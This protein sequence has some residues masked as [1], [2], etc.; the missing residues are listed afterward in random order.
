[1]R[2]PSAASQT[3]QATNLL[4]DVSKIA[5]DEPRTLFNGWLSWEGSQALAALGGHKLETLIDSARTSDFRPVP[6]GITTLDRPGGGCHGQ[7]HGKCRGHP[8]WC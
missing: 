4:V 6:P 3:I 2:N 8:A 1:M 5:G 7:V